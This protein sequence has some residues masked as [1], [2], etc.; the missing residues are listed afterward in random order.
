MNPRYFRKSVL[1]AVL[2]VASLQASATAISLDFNSLPSAQG[3]TYFTD[4][5][6][7]EANVFSIAGGVLSMDSTPSLTAAYYKLENV[8]DPNLRFVLTTRARVL[9]G[10]RALAF[11]V[12]TNGPLARF[13]ISP[14]AIIDETNSN[15]WHFLMPRYSIHIAWKEIFLVITNSALTISKS[16]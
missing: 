13:N 7:P 6:T 10:D 12:S 14:G 5:T 2:L 15:I 11:Y 8:V 9:S 16:G 4:G 1:A 3:W